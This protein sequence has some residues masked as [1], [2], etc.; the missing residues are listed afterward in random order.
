M[1]KK[2]KNFFNY[3][4]YRKYENWGVWTS[5]PA[6]WN[7][8]ATEDAQNVCSEDESATVMLYEEEEEG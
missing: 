3:I 6:E 8:E 4:I 2:K 1:F 5:W 7:I